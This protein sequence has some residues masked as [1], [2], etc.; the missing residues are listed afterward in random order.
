ML[1]RRGH[2]SRLERPVAP[3]YPRFPADCGLTGA[4]IASRSAVVSNDV[5]HDPRYL[6]ALD[7]TG[8]EAIIPI[9]REGRVV[10]TLDVEDERI[11]AFDQDQLQVFERIGAAMPTLF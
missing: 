3:A 5:A 4:S 1:R 8:S 9:L 7:S 6:T 11:G 2:K 10:G